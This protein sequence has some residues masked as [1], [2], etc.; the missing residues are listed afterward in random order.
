[1]RA[2]YTR[3]LFG[4]IYAITVLGSILLG[5]FVFGSLILIFLILSLKEYQ[6]FLDKADIHLKTT[7]FYASNIFLYVFAFF[8][9]Y[10]NWPLSYYF[11][12]VV[13]IYVPFVFQVLL[14]NIRPLHETG[15]YLVSH[16]Y[17]AIP[18][19]LLSYLFQLGTKGDYWINFAVFSFFLLIWVNDSFAYII[20]STMGRHKLNHVVSPNKTWEGSIGGFIFTLLASYLLHLVFPEQGLLKWFGFAL[21]T[22]IFGTFGDLFESVAKRGILIKESGNIIPGH[23]GILDRLDS[24]LI[25]SPFV[26]FYFLILMI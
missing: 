14:K 23:G 10:L 19:A 6:N 4:A 25:A 8:A 16:F 15:Q 13:I 1:L 7:W 26:F 2:F 11:I 18:L 12:P 20:G 24:L 5:P 22:V 21:I 9:A 3:T 17:L